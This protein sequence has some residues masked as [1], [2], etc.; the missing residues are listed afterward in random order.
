M[1]ILIYPY[2]NRNIER[3]KRSLESLENQTVSDF[4]VVFVDYGSEL[5][6]SSAIETLLENYDFVNY[7]YYP[8]RF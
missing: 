6:I 3:V 4:S 5:E 1:L 2:R 8:T 7:Q